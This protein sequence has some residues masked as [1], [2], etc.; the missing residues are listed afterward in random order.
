M[1]PIGY[2]PL[3]IN[4]VQAGFGQI[5]KLKQADPSVDL[6]QP[7]RAATATTRRSSPANP[8]VNHLA[9]IAPPPPACDKQGAGPCADGVRDRER[10]PGREQALRPTTAAANSQTGSNSSTGGANSTARR[11]AGPGLV[12]AAPATAPARPPARPMAP[13]IDPNTGQ[14]V[15]GSGTAATGN[16]TGGTVI[17]TPTELASS[18]SSQAFNGVLYVLAV[19]LLLVVLIAPVALSRYLHAAGGSS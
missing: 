6:T 5:A 3:P 12:R 4:L 15:D 7:Q 2:S 17:G 1:G 11:A 18:Q 13:H 19:L 10:Q 9:Q 8:N 16:G 14:L